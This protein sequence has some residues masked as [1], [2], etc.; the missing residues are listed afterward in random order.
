MLR[1]PASRNSL[2]P[3]D[4]IG[5][6]DTCLHVAISASEGGRTLLRSAAADALSHC[7]IV[8]FGIRSTARGR[9]GDGAAT[10]AGRRDES[11]Q[12]EETT[13]DSDDD[14]GE[15]DPTEEEGG[16]AAQAWRA[17]SSERGARNSGTATKD[18]NFSVT[19]RG[20]QWEE[21]PALV[22]IMHRLAVLAD[23]LLHEDAQNVL[24]L[25]LVNIALE[26]MPDV[27]ALSV[28]YPRLL[29]IMQNDLCRNL[30]RLST[31]PDLS[32]FGLGLRVIFN[33]FNSIKDHLKVSCLIL[34][35]LG[36][37]FLFK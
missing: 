12:T 6:F 11:A 29:T 1:C 18:E 10:C 8:L 28:R 30:L 25:S 32:I 37:V 9:R 23:P 31:S 36:L 15:R 5:I 19:A 14:W 22:P 24:A 35:G 34:R 2:L 21:E 33:L 17:L 16:N 13:E 7:V 26:T 3:S 4:A 20:M 27:D